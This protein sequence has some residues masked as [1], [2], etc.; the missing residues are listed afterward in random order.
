MTRFERRDRDTGFIGGG[1]PDLFDGMIKSLWRI[2][3]EEYD[4]LLDGSSDEELDLIIPNDKTPY[5]D[6]KKGLVFVNTKLAK[7]YEG[8]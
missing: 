4:Y 1:L 8:L 2:N 5:S 7:M 3:E 6:I